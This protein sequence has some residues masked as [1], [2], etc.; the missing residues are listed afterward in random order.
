MRQVQ[1]LPKENSIIDLKGPFWNYL[2]DEPPPVAD[3]FVIPI[4]NKVLIF[5]SLV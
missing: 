4:S 2:K 5:S 3:Y 1:S